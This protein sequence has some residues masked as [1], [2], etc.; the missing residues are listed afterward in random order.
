MAPRML[1]SFHYLW[2]FHSN[3]AGEAH[4]QTAGGLA[5][6][7]ALYARVCVRGGRFTVLIRTGN[8]Y[9]YLAFFLT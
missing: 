4:S 1:C 6:T 7:S 5:Q 9:L 2:R 3:E 8:R